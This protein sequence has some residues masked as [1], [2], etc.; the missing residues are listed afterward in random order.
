MG[1]DANCLLFGV[2]LKECVEK[3]ICFGRK[4]VQSTVRSQKPG[5][6]VWTGRAESADSNE[7]L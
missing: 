7:S 6:H 2:R 5:L 1:A 3:I 4:C